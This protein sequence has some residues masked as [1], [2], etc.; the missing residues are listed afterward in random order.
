MFIFK[1]AF[2]KDIFAHLLI[3]ILVGSLLAMAT[4]YFADDYFGGAISGL[5]G[6]Y[7]E[8]DLLVMVNKQVKDI[9]HHQLKEIIRQRFPGAQLKQGLSV[10]GK[11]NY[12]VTLPDKYKTRE[13]YSNLGK[14]FSNISGLNSITIMTEP[15][16]SIRGVPGGAVSL[17]EEELRKIPGVQFTFPI[18]GGIDLLL[19]SPER[20]DPASSRIQKILNRY[21][22]VEARFPMGQEPENIVSLGEEMAL[23]AREEFKL[24]FVKN[25]TT[26]DQ[27]YHDYLAKTLQEM[28]RFM[29]HY[30][31]I[32]EL[33]VPK[34]GEEPLKI[35]ER[36]VLP[37]RSKPEIQPGEEVSAGMVVLEVES[38]TTDRIQALIS[39]GDVQDISGNTAYRVTYD[40]KVG[41]VYGRAELTS[42]REELRYAV[43]ETQKVLPELDQIFQ[44]TYEVINEA[45]EAIEVYNSSLEQLRQAQEVLQKGQTQL[46]KLEGQF[47]KID[48]SSIVNIINQMEEGLTR[49]EEGS[50]KID[51]MREE[52]FNINHRLAQSKLLLEGIGSNTSDPVVRQELDRLYSLVDKL[53]LSLTAQIGNIIK[54]LTDYQ[55]MLNTINRWKGDL[56]QLKILVEDKDFLDEDSQKLSG[57][58]KTIAEQSG[59]FI[60][61]LLKIDDRMI[62]NNLVEIRDKLKKVQKADVAAVMEQLSYLNQALP[63]LKDEE[64]TNTIKL[65]DQYLA[66]QVIP[67]ERVRLLFPGSFPVKKAY[68]VLQEVAG[69]ARLS[70]FSLEVGELRP[71]IRGELF[72]LLNEVRK[73]LTAVAAIIF[74]L[75]ILLFDHSVIMAAI[76]EVR[77]RFTSPLLRLVNTPRIY[78]I[79][80]GSITLGFMFKFTGASLPYT[81]QNEAFILGAV[82]GLIVS[83]LANRINPLDRQ[84]FI[85]GEAM[86]LSLTQILREIVVPA[87]KPGLLLLLNKPRQIF[88]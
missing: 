31:T 76:D 33:P 46:E 21:Q 42:V 50:G 59:I 30:A 20:V 71:N 43:Q 34:E 4:G 60:E 40:G 10:A 68:P 16:I 14:I 11:S 22:V 47:G 3:T 9:A 25:I 58:F 37:S 26:S 7:G 35:G 2:I 70:I 67:G 23:R 45:L 56:H 84:E 69:Q 44:R 78:G 17:L 87:G 57:L 38:I 28:K 52:L 75:F 74:T 6:E 48:T 85:A 8:Y 88:K 41:Q 62:S 80:M 13:I 64:I 1:S 54:K 29:I 72:M 32:V 15:R 73:T 77:G 24:D 19:D 63:E 12:F 53:Q 65:L 49:L 61:K 79:L 66:G 39:L 18:A 51:E 81:R 5:I 55:P 86:G 83:F 36:L 82:L 27:E